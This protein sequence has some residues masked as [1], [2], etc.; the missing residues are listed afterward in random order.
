MCLAVPGKVE[1]ID[2]VDPVLRS[3]RVSFGGI[4]KVVSLACVPEATVGDYVLVHAGMAISTVDESE[5]EKVFAYLRELG[6]FD[7]LAASSGDVP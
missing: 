5:A 4:V 3:G 1:S 7:D 2:D 6:E